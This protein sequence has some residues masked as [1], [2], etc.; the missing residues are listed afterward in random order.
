MGTL[1]EDQ[2]TFLIISHSFL[3]RMRNVSGKSCRENKNTH[4]MLNNF[5]LNC[6]IYGI[7]WKNIVELG[8][9]QVTVRHMQIACWI[10]KATTNTHSEYVVFNAFLLQQWLHKPVSV[11]RYMYIACLFLCLKDSAAWTLN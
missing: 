11:L 6:A 2:Y 8:R 3:L 4:F 10:C 5:F 9:P 7:M 1:N